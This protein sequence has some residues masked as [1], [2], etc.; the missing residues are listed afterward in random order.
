MSG[1]LPAGFRADLSPVVGVIF[2]RALH[3]PVDLT[4]P[5]RVRRAQQQ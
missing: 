2:Y 1:A 3:R 5:E 4:E